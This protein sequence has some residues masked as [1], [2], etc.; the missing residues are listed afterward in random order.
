MSMNGN[1]HSRQV[2]RQAGM[3]V[4]ILAFALIGATM[5]RPA[6]APSS[7][8]TMTVTAVANKQAATPAINKN[9]VNLFQGNERTQIAD[10]RRG[11]SLY[12]AILI[13]DSLDPA[14][15]LDWNDLRAF[16]NSQPPSTYVG[17]AYSRNGSAMIAQNF[18]N[19]HALAAKA[20]HMPTNAPGAYT[21]PYLAVQDWLKRWPAEGGD[22]RSIMLFSSGIDY[23]RGGFPPYDTDIDPTIESAQ[24][25]NV[26]VWSIYYPDR[27]GAA[28][29][30]RSFFAETNLDKVSQETGGES[31]FLSLSR[32][33]TLKPYFDEIQNR[34]NNQYLLSFNASS[35]AKKGRFER[36]RVA[37]EISNV[38]FRA[39][40]Q[41]FLPSAR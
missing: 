21:S 37:T 40:N 35:G 2:L 28:R 10:L 4:S 31:F 38:R 16:I 41:V 15:S 39:P 8:V 7:T 33:V 27:G 9:D 17:V 6:P 29:G 25:H 3:A 1:F 36:V 34:L 24:K 14:V 19:D 11:D 26:N 5:A 30:S 12:L 13:D 20:V 22:R 32:P 23:F 18:T